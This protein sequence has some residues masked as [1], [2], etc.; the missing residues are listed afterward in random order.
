MSEREEF[1]STILAHQAEAEAA[2]AL[3][4]DVEPRLALWSRR[5]PVTLFGAWGPCKTGW[6]EVSR[7]FR[8]WQSGLRNRR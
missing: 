2:L 1:R 5:D 3:R 8:W 4:G 6:A 7:T